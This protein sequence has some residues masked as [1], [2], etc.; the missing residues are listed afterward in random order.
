[1]TGTSNNAST[2]S[3]IRRPG[4]CV[5]WAL[6]L[7]TV[8]PFQLVHSGEY[9]EWLD[10]KTDTS[11]RREAEEWIIRGEALVRRIERLLREW[12]AEK[13][14]D[15][16]RSAVQQAVSDLQEF[17]RREKEL[18]KSA[19]DGCREA[20]IPIDRC[21]AVVRHKERLDDMKRHERKLKAMLNGGAY[22]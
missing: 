1:M 15:L 20:G 10:E 6:V 8:L 22:E 19:S 18:K 7:L 12:H 14:R 11:L 16:D 13:N 5:G 21:P 2:N 3:A 17:I 9:S 4:G